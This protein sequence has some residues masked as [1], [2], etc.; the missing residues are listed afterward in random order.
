LAELPKEARDGTRVI[1]TFLDTSDIDLQ[2]RGIDQVQADELRSQLGTFAE[3][4]DS[5]G[6]ALYNQYD[7]NKAKL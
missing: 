6:M 2:A 4:W 3:E 5:P 7:A 1:V